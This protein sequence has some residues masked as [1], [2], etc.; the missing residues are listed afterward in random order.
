MPAGGLVNNFLGFWAWREIELPPSSAGTNTFVG[1][2]CPLGGHEDT[3]TTKTTMEVVPLGHFFVKKGIK[4][5][6]FSHGDTR[7]N[8]GHYCVCATF[9]EGPPMTRVSCPRVFFEGKGVE[10]KPHGGPFLKLKIPFFRLE[11]PAGLWKFDNMFTNGNPTKFS[12]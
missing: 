12:A 7:D 3:I 2:P 9:F 5:A 10:Y 6:H 11:H 4:G 8:M 1:V